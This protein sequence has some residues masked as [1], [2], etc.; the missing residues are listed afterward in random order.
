MG[1]I[2][3]NNANNEQVTENVALK[4][5]QAHKLV[6]ETQVDAELPQEQQE[7]WDDPA[8]L[9]EDKRRI[10]ENSRHY[11]L[12]NG[13]SKSVF[14]AESVSFFDET[15]KKWKH[16]D[17]SLE[18]KEDVFESKS[19]KLKTRIS[20][21]HNGKKVAISK[22]DKQISWEYLGKQNSE[23][24]KE[25]FEDLAET[26]L[27]VNNGTQ[28]VSKHINSSAVYEN[29]EKNTDLE[30][31][32]LGN[33]L[34]ENIIVKEKS[35]KYRYLFALKM[36]GLKLRLSEDNKNLELY[37]EIGKEDGTI[38]QKIEFTI[39][40]PYMYDANGVAS[41]DVYYE[42]EPSKEGKFTFAVIANEEWINAADRVFPVTIDPQFVTSSSL[43]TKETYCRNVYSSSISGSGMTY[44]SWFDTSITNI[45]VSRSNVEEYKTRLTIKKN[46]IDLLT[47]N[48]LSAKLIL[49]P[50]GSF[51]GYLYCDGEL[52]YYNTSNGNLE[53]Y[54]T[55]SFR[56][57]L[58]SFSVT[59]EP[60]SYTDMQFFM[61]G[62]APKI[63]IRTLTD[64]NVLPVKK[65]IFFGGGG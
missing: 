48:I 61:S 31:C 50:C 20:K 19:G 35:T 49:T 58:N 51:S 55:K 17:N 16:I 54:I 12:N 15:E 4:E 37:S 46:Q 45:K 13:T 60:Y 47:D 7:Q 63:E 27:K 21:V 1:I 14:N 26:V 8:I 65:N 42:L 2:K 22:S 10:N 9:R 32:L 28:G 18:E 33:N 43:I 56:N 53:I 59:L 44:G 38:E 57:N 24:A 52:T 64:E 39:P 41:D 40:S 6:V 30:Y 62:E 23:V 29:I 36:E 11:V 25:N 3:L 5:Q 34:K